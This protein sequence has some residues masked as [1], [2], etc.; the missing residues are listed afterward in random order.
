MKR[1][2]SLLLSVSVISTASAVSFDWT[3]ASIKFNDAAVKASTAV[4]GYLVYIG[5]ATSVESVDISSDTISTI[6]SN[7]GTQVSEKNKPN[8]YSKLTGT[9]AFDFGSKVNG[10]SFAMLL[11]Y[12]DSESG[13]TYYNLSS[14][15][16]TLSGLTDET[17]TPDDAVFTFSYASAGSSSKATAGGGWTAVPE[18][19]TAALALAGLALLIRRRK[20]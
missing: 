5:T 12:A 3:A 8:A 4:T 19:S 18:P 13:K 6:T 16:Y 20:A 15:V 14:T 7:L 11:T 10:D 2:L 17:S 1:I 9:Y